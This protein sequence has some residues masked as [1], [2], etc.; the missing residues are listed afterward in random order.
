M[1]RHLVITL[2][3]KS[4]S[5][6]NRQDPGRWKYDF[7]FVH[8]TGFLGRVL[9]WSFKF[10]YLQLQF[11]EQWISEALLQKQWVWRLN[12]D[13]CW[14]QLL[15]AL[16]SVLDVQRCPELPLEAGRRLARVRIFTCHPPPPTHLPLGLFVAPKDW[17][18]N[19]SL[20]SKQTLYVFCHNKMANFMA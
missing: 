6:K 1:F 14:E 20:H 13:L 3:K 18:K 4:G 16:S 7:A 19:H 15:P 5:P 11:C 8:Q 12:I 2:P 17:K 9:R 10:S